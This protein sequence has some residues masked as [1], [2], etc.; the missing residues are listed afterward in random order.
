MIRIVSPSLLSADFGHF[1]DEIAL[2]NR[3]EAEWIHV[4]V[5]DGVY[6]PNI[7]FGF[8]VI[9]YVRPLTDKALDVH[10]MIVHPEKFL[11]RFRDAGADILTVHAEACTHLHRTLQEIRS[12]GMKAGV[13][14]NPHTP[15]CMVEEVLDDADMVL[16]MTVDPGFGG[17]RFIPRCLDKVRRFRRIINGRGLGTL[18]QVDGGVSTENAGELYRAGSNVLVAGHAVFASPDPAATIAAL[19]HAE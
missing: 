7:S 16:V 17:Q 19:L 15:L 1:A 5:M 4:D 13:A 18:I 3:S 10:L 14:L 11:A 9:E 12:L 2:L 8:P 6:V